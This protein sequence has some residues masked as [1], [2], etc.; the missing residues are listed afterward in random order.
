MRTTHLRG[1]EFRLGQMVHVFNYL[2]PMLMQSLD[3][4]GRATSPETP[5]CGRCFRVLGDDPFDGKPG[6][7]R[8][9]KIGNQRHCFRCGRKCH[10]CE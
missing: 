4:W 7:L 1:P 6:Q 9:L 8:P 10:P 3:E 5:I 2:P